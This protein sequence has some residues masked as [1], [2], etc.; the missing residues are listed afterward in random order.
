MILS[1]SVV[2]R[3]ARIE[4]RAKADGTTEKFA[5]EG[6]AVRLTTYVDTGRLALGIELPPDTKLE[7]EMVRVTSDYAVVTV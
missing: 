1:L 7:G 2:L 6:S 3:P 4:R 5:I